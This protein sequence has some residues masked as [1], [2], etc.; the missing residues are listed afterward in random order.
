MSMSKTQTPSLRIQSNR[1][2]WW[3]PCC[4]D[5]ERIW[6]KSTCASTA[7]LRVIEIVHSMTNGAHKELSMNRNIIIMSPKMGTQ[8]IFIRRWPSASVMTSCA[9][10]GF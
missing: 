5:G 2:V 1:L 7:A 4:D 8:F 10:Y 3:M 6:N 9:I